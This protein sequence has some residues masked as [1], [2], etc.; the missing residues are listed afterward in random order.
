VGKWADCD[1]GDKLGPYWKVELNLITND[2]NDLEKRLELFTSWFRE[3]LRELP[4]YRVEV[5]R[6]GIP[7]EWNIFYRDQPEPIDQL[8]FQ[9]AD[10]A[11]MYPHWTEP[12]RRNYL[13]RRVQAKFRTFGVEI[14]PLN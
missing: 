8:L 12:Q 9:N 1:L 13:H 10:I 4:D 5:K 6:T 14:A 2:T 11:Q 3:W 7:F